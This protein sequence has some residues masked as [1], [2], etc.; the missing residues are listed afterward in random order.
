VRRFSGSRTLL[1]GYVWPVYPLMPIN[2]AVVHTATCTWKVV[3]TGSCTM[4]MQGVLLIG[5][6][7]YRQLYI[8]AVET[9]GSCIYNQLSLKTVVHTSSWTHGQLH[10]GSCAYR[11]LY[12]EARFTKADSVCIHS[13][14]ADY[15][16]PVIHI[17]WKLLAHAANHADRCSNRASKV[18]C[19]VQMQKS[20][21]CKHK[22]W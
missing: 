10:T 17:E 13:R 18:R 22:V 12:T 20:I 7:T 2:Q 14:G 21:E 8:Y 16:Q 9:T 3:H 11:L 19:A 15:S 4:Y 6:C 5:S 1:I